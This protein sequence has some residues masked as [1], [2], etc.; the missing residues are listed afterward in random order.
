[1]T[2][3]ASWGTGIVAAANIVWFVLLVLAWGTTPRIRWA[4]YVFDHAAGVLLWGGPMLSAFIVAYLAPHKKVL[5]GM[6]MALPAT[7]MAA[8]GVW[9]Y[10]MLGHRVDSVGVAGQALALVWN[11]L[12]CALAGTIGYLLSR[13]G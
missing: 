11:L 12:L 7:I 2:R 10:E 9:A 4:V 3:A 13:N 6:S 1:L 8:I 5:L